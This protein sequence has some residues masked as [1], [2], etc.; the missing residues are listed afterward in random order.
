MN[1][2]QQTDHQASRKLFPKPTKTEQGCLTRVLVGHKSTVVTNHTSG[3][4]VQ[5]VHCAKLK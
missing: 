4:N 5:L 3:K 2:G 1:K